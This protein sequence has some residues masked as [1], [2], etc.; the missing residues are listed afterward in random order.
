MIGRRA[1]ALVVGLT[2]SASGA[3]VDVRRLGVE[4]AD[5]QQWSLLLAAAPAAGLALLLL[6]DRRR[7]QAAI[8]VVLLGVW[9]LIGLIGGLSGPSP[10][11]A[12]LASGLFAGL[13]AAAWSLVRTAGWSPLFAVLAGVA[14]VHGAAGVSLR[15]AGFIPALTEEGRLVLLAYEP[16]HLARIAA[17]GAVA[18]VSLALN[19]G[20][21]WIHLAAWP[22]VVACSVAVLLTQSRTGAAA[23][24]FAIA[25][26]VIRATRPRLTLVLVAVAML[27]V[28]AIGVSGLAG[29]V[30]ETISR[31]G[32]RSLADIR[33]GNGRTELWP[34]VI[35][36]WM[37]TP[38]VG[39]GPGTD[40]AVVSEMRREGEIGWHAEHSHSLLLHVLMTSGAAGTVAFVGAIWAGLISGWRRANPWPLAL[41]VLVG[42]DGLSEAVLS[43]P[44]PAWLVIAGSMVEVRSRATHIRE[45]RGPRIGGSIRSTGRVERPSAPDQRAALHSLG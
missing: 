20:R 8:G 25:V 13:G 4:T 41:L 33:T 44:G 15:A 28:G 42:V 12:L 38:F 36:A 27:T 14:A 30:V 29:P 9:T 5:P 32:D 43:T 2:A 10:S 19:A 3:T 16:N 22:V 31:T 34:A 23:M 39:V 6:G 45:S 17:L 21:S 1:A 11:Q 37:D 7:A 40:F 24:A 26:P 35:Q 18:A